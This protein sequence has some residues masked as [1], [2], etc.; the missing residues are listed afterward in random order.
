[1][2]KFC[3]M[4]IF[5]CF[6]PF[7]S[8]GSYCS[9]AGSQK[10]KPGNNLYYQSSI[11]TYIFISCLSPWNTIASSLFILVTAKTWHEIF[12][13]IYVLHGLHDSHHYVPKNRSKGSWHLEN[14]CLTLWSGHYFSR[15][16]SWHMVVLHC[17]KPTQLP[18]GNYILPLKKWCSRK[19]LTKSILLSLLLYI[20]THIP[21][22]P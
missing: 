4:A 3:H 12:P 1:M 16:Y 13:N 21:L 5:N 11:T 15:Q 8:H 6:N 2:V 14:Q 22:K 17:L 20:K 10:K 7:K 19:H 9:L 18:H